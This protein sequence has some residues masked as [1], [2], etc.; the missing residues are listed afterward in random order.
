MLDKQF[1]YKKLEM[2]TGYID[3]LEQLI[4]DKDL[5]IIKKDLMLLAAIE[6]YFQLTVDLMIDINIHIIRE[7][8]LGAPDEMQSTFK[9]LGEFKALD[10]SFAERIAPIVGARN[11]I[12]HRYDKLDK[13]L[14]LRNLKNNFSDFKTYVMEIQSFI[15][16]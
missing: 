15:K 4:A 6:R 7:N 12:V 5:E 16:K 13:D 14:F 9:Q 3:F 8:N 10:Q 1:I 2:L 11:M